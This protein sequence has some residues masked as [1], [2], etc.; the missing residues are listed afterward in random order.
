MNTNGNKKD[1]EESK[2]DDG[3][4]EDRQTAGLHVRK[5]HHSA[6]PWQLKQ[7]PRA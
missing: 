3:V 6:T 4:D 5:S 2:K 7:Q 1:G